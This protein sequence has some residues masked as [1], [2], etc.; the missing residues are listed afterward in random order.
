MPKEPAALSRAIRFC[1]IDSNGKRIP[2]SPQGAADVAIAYWSEHPDADYEETFRHVRS[3]FPT[4]NIDGEPNRAPGID[5]EAICE[6]IALAHCEWRLDQQVHARQRDHQAYLARH[7]AD[8]KG[9]REEG[10]HA[11]LEILQQYEVPLIDD[12]GVAARE[13]DEVREQIGRGKSP[14]ADDF[15]TVL[16]SEAFS[17]SIKGPSSGTPPRRPAVGALFHQVFHDLE[18]RIPGICRDF[19]RQFL[20]SLEACKLVTRST[21]ELRT[22]LGESETEDEEVWRFAATPD[23]QRSPSNRSWEPP[24]GFVGMTNIM[25]DMRFKKN[26][27]NPPRTTIQVW[28]DKA[29][30]SGALVVGETYIKAPDNKMVYVPESWVT[31][32]IALWNPRADK[33]E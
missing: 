12:V 14:T 13:A 31:G 26:G 6:G 24:P 16:K 7:K 30:K 22:M 20:G 25:F 15:E 5:D 32:Q 28:T 21:V 10:E 9:V 17:E 29:R 33:L 23:G 1:P 11:I 4:P 18:T 8:P 3:A 2:A 27:K 19:C